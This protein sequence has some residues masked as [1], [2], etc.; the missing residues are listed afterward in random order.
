MNFSQAFLFA[1]IITFLFI[2]SF[3]RQESNFSV[4]KGFD[5]QSASARRASLTWVLQSVVHHGL[6]FSGLIWKLGFV[7]LKKLWLVS[8]SVLL[9]KS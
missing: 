8:E 6:D 4:E 7:I 9:N 3:F 1:L 5:R 2:A